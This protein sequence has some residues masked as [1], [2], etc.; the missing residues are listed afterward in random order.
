MSQFLIST[1]RQ[2]SGSMPSQFGTSSRKGFFT[3]IP[4]Y[5][6]ISDSQDATVTFDTYANRGVGGQLEYRYVISP[7]DRGRLYG[8]FVDEVFQGGGLRGFGSVKQDWQISPGLSLR[9]DLNAVSDDR[10]L[11]DYVS[12]LQTRAAQRAE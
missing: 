1:S 9:S 6:V 3:E 12:S 11:R 10:V 8:Y 2:W 7:D 4:F 5:W